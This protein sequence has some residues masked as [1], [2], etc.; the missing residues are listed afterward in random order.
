MAKNETKT[1]DDEI[2]EAVEKIE[3]KEAP[4]APD[5]YEQVLIE[6]PISE[7][8]QDDW[9]CAINGK[10]WQ[11]KRGERVLVPRCVKEVYDNERR[12]VEES[13][14]RSRALQNKLIQKEKMAFS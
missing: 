12:M 1:I 9:F 10:T 13:I 8:E 7:Q 3:K 4:K 2:K 5:P 11:V 14:K 6:I